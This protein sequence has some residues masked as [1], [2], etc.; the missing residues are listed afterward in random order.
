MRNIQ[1]PPQTGP[2]KVKVKGKTEWHDHD[3]ACID[4]SIGM[5]YSESDKFNATC[6]W[7]GPRFKHAI[8][9]VN[10]TLQRYNHMFE[11]G[12]S[13]QDAIEL[14]HKEGHAWIARNIQYLESFESYTINRWDQYLEHPNFKSQL[15]I[16]T[17]RFNQDPDF[18]QAVNQMVDNIWHRRYHKRTDVAFRR[19]EFF[20]F[21]T[22]YLL[23]E[24]AVFSNM[25]QDGIEH[26][27]YPGTFLDLA[28]QFED[29]SYTR[30][31]FSKNKAL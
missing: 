13:E 28:K 16:V 19:V 17:D 9:S 7:T 10:D 23:E 1:Y 22:Q 14:C 26:H 21:S 31:D 4:I 24:I 5:P 29:L 11:T 12:M 3:T 6:L 2:Y 18:K 27:I 30:I 25:A 15:K 20:D 8:I